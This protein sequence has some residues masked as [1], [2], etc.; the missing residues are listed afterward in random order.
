MEAIRSRRSIRHYTS[1]GVTEDEIR[2]LLE[3]A[4]C[5]P[6]AGNERPW[7][8]VVIEDRPTLN[9]LSKRHP[10]A[11]MLREAPLAIL[12]CADPSLEKHAGFWVQDCAA[13]TQ[14]ILLEA[15]DLGL[16][17]VWLGV[18]PVED[19]VSALREICKLPES[20]TPFALVSVGRPAERKPASDRYDESRVHRNQW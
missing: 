15:E 17:A 11:N 3:A 20:I 10:Y 2:N 5:A 4:M 12:I 7:H 9:E 16:G 1:E 14:N 19:R 13:A 18:H 6:S 8:F